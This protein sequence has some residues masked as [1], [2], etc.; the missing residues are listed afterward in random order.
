MSKFSCQVFQKYLLVLHTNLL[1]FYSR[2]T[3]RFYQCLLPSPLPNF[4]PLCLNCGCCLHVS[5]C[6][7]PTCLSVWCYWISHSLPHQCTSDAHTTR[8]PIASNFWLS[9]SHLTLPV[10]RYFAVVDVIVLQIGLK[11]LY[12]SAITVVL[13]LPAM[14]A[15]VVCMRLVFIDYC[16]LHE[17]C[18][19]HAVPT[20]GD[21]IR[22]SRK[23]WCNFKC[24][25]VDVTLI[26]VYIFSTRTNKYQP[27]KCFIS[28]LSPW[29]NLSVRA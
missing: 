6:C 15:V 13:I 18:C 28:A 12:V 24:F 21:L 9:A 25:D 19:V 2:F 20:V 26:V 23:T 7:L 11:L 16:C 1:A 17:A 27:P 5:C 14:I 4:V 8:H 10:H 22:I 29:L 3:Q